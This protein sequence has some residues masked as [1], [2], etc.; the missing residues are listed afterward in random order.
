MTS[1][2]DSLMHNYLF[3]YNR[4]NNNVTYVIA[5]ISFMVLYFVAAIIINWLLLMKSNTCCELSI[6]HLIPGRI[7]FK[8]NL[9]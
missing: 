1:L 5:V 3:R 4:N 9:L 7:A 8:F 6:C 2:V